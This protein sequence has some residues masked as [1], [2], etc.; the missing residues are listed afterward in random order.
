MDRLDTIPE[1]VDYAINQSISI[2]RRRSI[3]LYTIV[4]PL[5]F[6]I[7]TKSKSRRDRSK[8]VS[9]CSLSLSI[10]GKPRGRARGENSV[11]EPAIA[12]FAR[13]LELQ[14]AAATRSTTTERERKS[15]E[16]ISRVSA[17]VEIGGETRNRY[18]RFN[19][20]YTLPLERERELFPCFFLSSLFLRSLLGCCYSSSA[21]IPSKTS[22]NELRKT[23]ARATNDIMEKN[24]LFYKIDDQFAIRL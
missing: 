20:L 21:D 18:T 13:V 8:K 17:R 4:D 16:T 9:P 5:F 19:Y 10:P 11:V 23:R 22:A 12:L 15:I 6:Y 1:D 2:E 7:H 24:L 14:G 3:S